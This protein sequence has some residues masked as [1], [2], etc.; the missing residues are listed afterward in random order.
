MYH[1]CDGK[2]ILA[3][4]ATTNGGR[5]KKY[6]GELGVVRSVEDL[7]CGVLA[8]ALEAVAVAVH[9]QDV[10]VVCQAVQQRPGE[11]LRAQNLGPFVEGEVG[12]D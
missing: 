6:R 1:Q 5:R 9:L 7:G 12:G 4:E 10:D 2:S 3:R 8:A 11:T